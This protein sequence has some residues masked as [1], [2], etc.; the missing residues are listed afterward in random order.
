[1]PDEKSKPSLETIAIASQ[2]DIDAGQVWFSFPP[3]N[4]ALVKVKVDYP[5]IED[6][7]KSGD[8]IAI[9]D[10]EIVTSSQKDRDPSDNN[11]RDQLNQSAQ[12]SRK[13]IT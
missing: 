6:L 12:V 13:K 10:G 8:F 3:P 4:A 5:Q 7:L 1:M 2:E 11:S 9:Q